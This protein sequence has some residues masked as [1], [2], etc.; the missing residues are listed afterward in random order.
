MFVPKQHGAWAMLI[1]PF[2]LGV[3]A[4][5]FQ[6][7]HI[8]FFIGWVLLYLATYPF[9]MF[10]K[11]KDREF[12][13]KWTIIYGSIAIILLIIPLISRPSIILFGLACIPF[14]I[15][16]IFFSMKKNDRAL[17]NDLSAIVIFSVATLASSYLPNG[18][19]TFDAILVFISSFLFFVGTTFYVKTMIR[20]KKNVKYKWVSW[21]YHVAVPAA[22]FICG[23]P[24]IALSFVSSAI[25]AFYNYGKSLPIMK[26]GIIEI[27]NAAIYFVI[28]TIAIL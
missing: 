14:F 21:I 22:W 15:I 3:A 11:G 27:I 8:P 13:L 9:L 23:Y 26:L 16:N 12:Y 4:S 25:R 6:W 28:M 10:T 7:E 1:V 17:L 2:W 24:I 19:I 18:E 5:S 20:E